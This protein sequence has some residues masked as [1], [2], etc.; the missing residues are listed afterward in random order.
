MKKVQ[1]QFF[2]KTSSFFF[3]EK[4]NVLSPKS[5]KKRKI[6][7]PT[8][9][10]SS[11]LKKIINFQIQLLIEETE[12]RFPSE[13]DLEKLVSTVSECLPPPPKR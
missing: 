10:L 13:E 7:S 6:Y 12:E 9:I 3:F 8:K 11:D 5:E 1:K 4:L 2:L